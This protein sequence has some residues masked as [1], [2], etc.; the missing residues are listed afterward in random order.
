M[1]AVLWFDYMLTFWKQLNFNSVTIAFN[2]NYTLFGTLV[3]QAAI[4]ES[5]VVFSLRISCLCNVCSKNF[6]GR[7]WACHFPMFSAPD[8]EIITTDISSSRCID[9]SPPLFL[10]ITFKCC[11]VLCLH[12]SGG[13]VIHP[14]SC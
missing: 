5:G 4:W 13:T 12:R 7:T 8:P 1:G 3:L 11:P 6:F 10:Q 9:F 14:L 2:D